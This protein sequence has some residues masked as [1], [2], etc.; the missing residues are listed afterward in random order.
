MEEFNSNSNNQPD[1]DSDS[2]NLR[3]NFLPGVQ[4]DD[5]QWK[6]ITA[7]FNQHLVITAGPGSGKT[8]TIAARILYLLQKGLVD[9]ASEILV[10]TF[11]KK[12][13]VEMRER[14]NNFGKMKKFL[15]LFFDFFDS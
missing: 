11:S 13:S 15:I 4:F 7:N 14:L 8:S 12:A 10:L 5:F 6:A 3:K 9:D 2:E 1:I